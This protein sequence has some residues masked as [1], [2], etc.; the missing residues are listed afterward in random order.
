MRLSRDVDRSALLPHDGNLPGRRR[1]YDTRFVRSH[2]T[3]QNTYNG[4][5]SGEKPGIVRLGRSFDRFVI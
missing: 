4:D 3:E 2:A 5:D 1:Y